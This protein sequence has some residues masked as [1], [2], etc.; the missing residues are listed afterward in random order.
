MELLYCVSS[1]ES[2]L[3]CLS[4]LLGASLLCSGGAADGDGDG[5]SELR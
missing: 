5:L 4:M 2:V 1:E 3:T